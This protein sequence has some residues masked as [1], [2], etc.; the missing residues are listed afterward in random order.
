M[1]WAM[2]GGGMATGASVGA[3]VHSA[4]AAGDIDISRL[5]RSLEGGA[6]GEGPS[7]TGKREQGVGEGAGRVILVLLADRAGPPSQVDLRDHAQAHTDEKRRREG[8]RMVRRM[9]CRMGN[10]K[11]GRAI[12]KS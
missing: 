11:R 12:A 6:M 8:R 10:W 3:E 4:S 2:V 9:V 1:A 5:I 7:G